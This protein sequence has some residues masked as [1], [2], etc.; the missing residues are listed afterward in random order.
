MGGYIE[1]PA[2]PV[3]PDLRNVAAV[4]KDA[5]TDCDIATTEPKVGSRSV[6]LVVIIDGKAYKLYTQAVE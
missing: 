5:L 1:N 4:L 6:M 2:P 3:D